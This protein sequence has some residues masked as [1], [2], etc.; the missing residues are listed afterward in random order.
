MTIFQSKMD[1][2]K[3]PGLYDGTY[4]LRITMETCINIFETALSTV[5]VNLNVQR[6]FSDQNNQLSTK[7]TI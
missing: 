2:F 4:L 1:E 3:I 7:K 5:K 6:F